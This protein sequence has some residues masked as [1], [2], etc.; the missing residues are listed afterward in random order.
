MAVGDNR[1][2]IHILEPLMP[3]VVRIGGSHAQRELWE[4]ML[5]V[6]SLRS[7]ENGKARALID[8]RLHRRPSP[9]DRKWRGMLEV[10]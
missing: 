2:A 1:A 6:A 10:H 7:G 4:D 5:I 8:R 3:D 9:R